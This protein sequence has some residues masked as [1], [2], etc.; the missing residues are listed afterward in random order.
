MSALWAMKEAKNMSLRDS[1][2]NLRAAHILETI[3]SSPTAS[4]PQA[5]G[6]PTGT[7]GAYRFVESDAFDAQ[8]ILAGHYHSTRNRIVA[9]GEDI[10]VL[11][12]GMDISLSSLKKTTG[13]GPVGV[14]YSRGIKT[15]NTLALNK[16][17][18]PLG[19]IDVKYWVRNLKGF[20][21]GYMRR[22]LK[23]QDKETYAWIESIQKTETILPKNLGYMFIGDGGADLYDVFAMKRR[24][25]SS[26]LI[27]LVQNRNINFTEKNPEEKLF[28]ALD[29][30]KPLGV[31][32]VTLPRTPTRAAREAKLNIKVKVVDIKPPIHRR[33][34]GKLPT[35]QITAISAC[36]VRKGKSKYTRKSKS[37]KRKTY[38]PIIW[39]LLTTK[40]VVSLEDA[41]ALV[42]LYA[43]R[44]LIERYHYILKEGCRIEKL[45]MES[46]ENL[47][48]TLAL[49]SIV[50]WRLMHIT[51]VARINPD[52]M[53]TIAFN[54]NEWQA[55]WCYVNKKQCAPLAPP[56]IKEVV[57][58][59]AKV[60]G[61][62]ARKGDGEPGAK[63]IW[64]GLMALDHITE[65]FVIFKGK[66][67][68]NG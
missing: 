22:T 21:K 15:H 47:K 14:K 37:K 24:L 38:E 28:D 49:Y 58:L 66:D 23:I 45:Q 1:R 20:G 68:G 13:L 25:N 59:I 11:S 30:V 41:A 35:L 63:V 16:E 53:C 3:A 51:Y 55:L 4:I 65:M 46:A 64:Q 27:H 12:D 10:V 60:G 6:S 19:L 5:N 8:D 32:T 18:V 54:S 36:E 61:F 43:K 2:R 44:W 7:K 29:S 26:L 17:F 67:V 56:T 9:A 33:K 31:I 42:Y 57:L 48:R 39:R 62:L 52:A 34:K 40:D 50:A